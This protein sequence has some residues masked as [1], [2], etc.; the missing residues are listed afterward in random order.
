M[1]L[2]CQTPVT[3]SQPNFRKLLKKFK[4]WGQNKTSMKLNQQNQPIPMALSDLNLAN[5]ENSL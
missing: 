3:I 2:M 4:H 5:Q 1:S